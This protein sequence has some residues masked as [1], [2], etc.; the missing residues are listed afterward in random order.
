MNEIGQS[1]SEDVA[2]RN[3]METYFNS[4]YGKFISE[5][6]LPV[7]CVSFY[8]GATKLDAIQQLE[9][10]SKT[11]NSGDASNKNN[12]GQLFAGIRGNELVHRLNLD[13]ITGPFREGL[14]SKGQ[15]DL[16][17]K[18]FWTCE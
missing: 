14:G 1:R 6:G 13:R 7:G 18:I 12:G 4:E 9:S 8:A 10:L 15:P 16:C 2:F 17:G 5:I 3:G 11:L